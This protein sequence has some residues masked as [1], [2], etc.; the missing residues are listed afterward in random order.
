MSGKASHG[1]CNLSTWEVE[2]KELR[3]MIS[4]SYTVKLRLKQ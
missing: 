1:D 4:P 2:A 3:A